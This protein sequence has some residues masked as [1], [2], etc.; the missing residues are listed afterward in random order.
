MFN[1]ISNLKSHRALGLIIILATGIYIVSAEPSSAVHSPIASPT[2][3]PAKPES[4]V[5]VRAHIDAWVSVLLK[6]G[7]T[8]IEL[9]TSIVE[10]DNDLSH[11]KLTLEELVRR[12][13]NHTVRAAAW[14]ALADVSVVSMRLS[15]ARAQYLSSSREL[16]SRYESSLNAA[17]IGIYLGE[18]DDVR[19]EL[20]ALVKANPPAAVMRRILYLSALYLVA[21]DRAEDSWNL[22]L[23][24]AIPDKNCSPEC[25]ALAASIGAANGHA[26]EVE[27]LK[28]QLFKQFPDH[29]ISKMAGS[30]NIWES[31]FLFAFLLSPTQVQKDSLLT[32]TPESVKTPPLQDVSAS[33]RPRAIQ[34]GFYA[35]RENADAIIGRINAKNK[36][37]GLKI[38]VVDDKFRV[39]HLISV[40]EDPNKVLTQLK[41][42]G[43]EGFFLF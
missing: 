18:L 40:S 22:L 37:I 5:D 21:R 20:D 14:A 26:V 9:V 34:I 30:K 2:T 13:S 11:L 42:V 41:D 7:E 6:A 43:I 8:R 38:E 4:D 39:V 28:N 12:S 24:Q 29:P 36:R 23:T 31:S 33:Q 15:D 32:V 19:T 3:S 1:E 10:K 17:G 35:K 16:P 27:T 25:L